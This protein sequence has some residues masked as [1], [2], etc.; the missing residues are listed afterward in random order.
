MPESST[1]GFANTEQFRAFVER[2]PEP[3]AVRRPSPVLIWGIV[4]AV[5]LVAIA[6]ALVT[7]A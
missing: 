7:F 6:V 2:D 5:V 4:G 1:D 3:P